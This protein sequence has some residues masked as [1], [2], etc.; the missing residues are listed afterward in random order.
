M[1]QPSSLLLELEAQRLLLAVEAADA[2][3]GMAGESALHVEGAFI[4][5]E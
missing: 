2:V 1:L 5:L 4:R 3:D